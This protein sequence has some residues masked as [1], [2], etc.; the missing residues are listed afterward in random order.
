MT[1]DTRTYTDILEV[2]EPEG[3]AAQFSRQRAL[4]L[5]RNDAIR[6]ISE[7]EAES[8]ENYYSLLDKVD[9]ESIAPIKQDWIYNVCG[10]ANVDS[11]SIPKVCFRLQIEWPSVRHVYYL[12]M[13]IY[14]SIL[15]LFMRMPLFWGGWGDQDLVDE[16]VDDMLSEMNGM[17]YE[18]VKRA[19]A[20][21]VLLNKNERERLN[22]AI[23]PHESAVH[24]R[25][26]FVFGETYVTFLKN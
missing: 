12:K 21:Y 23:T 1:V 14:L 11:Y 9:I 22:V 2:Q 26:E 13:C 19:I 8:H 6:P 10:M 4:P 15:L 5:A 16:M 24:R 25:I 3:A 20:D 7:I 18:S 17:Y